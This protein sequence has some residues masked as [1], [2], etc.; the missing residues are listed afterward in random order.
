MIDVSD[1]MHDPDFSSRYTVIRRSGKWEGARF[2]LGE[3]KKL[4]YY[5]PV[6]PATSKELEQLPEGDRHS[7][8]M[9]FYCAPPKTLH[10]T[11]EDGQQA[12]VSDEIVYRGHRYKVFSVKDW[13]EHGYICASAYKIGSA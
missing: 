5:G 7:G 13:S 10:I 2:V 6:Q 4:K 12:N 11:S 9:Q 8:T 3:P 1:L